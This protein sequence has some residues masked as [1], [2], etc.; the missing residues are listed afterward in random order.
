MHES[1]PINPTQIQSSR[2]GPLHLDDTFLLLLL[3]PFSYLSFLLISSTTYTSNQLL[4][5]V[6]IM[7]STTTT[8]TTSALIY[9]HLNTTQRR[10]INPSSLSSTSLFSQLDLDTTPKA[11]SISWPGRV[12]VHTRRCSRV[13][14]LFGGGNKD[15]NEKGEEGK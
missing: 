12:P 6:R 9:H 4:Y 10:R 2:D 5:Q 1:N 15:N 7:A 13:Y 3:L 8:A 14:G 11:L